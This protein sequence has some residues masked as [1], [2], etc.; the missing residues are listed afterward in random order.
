MKKEYISPVVSIV[1]IDNSI[2]NIAISGGDADQKGEVY[3]KKNTI[4]F[5]DEDDDDVAIGW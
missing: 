5:S 3:S 1:K 2:M 4:S